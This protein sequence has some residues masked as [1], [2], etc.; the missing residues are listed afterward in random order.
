MS[1]KDLMDLRAARVARLA[2]EARDLDNQGK[3]MEKQITANNQ[4]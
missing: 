1:Y 3:E 4:G 2:E